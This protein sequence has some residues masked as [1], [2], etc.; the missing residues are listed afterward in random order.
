MQTTVQGRLQIALYSEQLSTDLFFNSTYTL[1]C[2][3]A[4][5]IYCSYAGRLLQAWLLFFLYDT[6]GVLPDTSYIFYSLLRR[7]CLCVQTH[8]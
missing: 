8:M 3:F 2:N 4:N 7:R 1:L 6:H 5:A